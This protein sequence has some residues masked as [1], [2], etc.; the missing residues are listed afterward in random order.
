[1]PY[2]AGIDVSNHQGVIDWRR[3]AQSGIMFAIT[4]A[5]EG[6][7]FIDSTLQANWAGIKANGMYRGSYHFALPQINDPVDEAD[8]YL[9]TMHTVG[10]SVGDVLAVDV[11]EHYIHGPLPANTR[12]WLDQFVLSVHQELG[13]WP[14]IYTRLDLINRYGLAQSAVLG[15]CGLWLASWG[16]PT[17]PPAPR[18]WSVVA[19][20]QTGVGNAGT[21]PG[22]DGQIDLDAFNGEIVNFPKYG[23]PGTAPIPAPLPNHSVGP[24]I[25]Y[26]MSELLDGPATDEVYLTPQ[27]SEAVGQSGNIYRWVPSLGR[28]LVFFPE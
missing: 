17:P 9:R 11:E 23:I 15:Q 1:M 16:V 28:V 13:L 2:P 24:G 14:L 18:P 21:V 27:W 26:K 22:V 25:M 7:T 12:P 3:V 10:L 19:V 5:T 6:L 20:H 4:K 8:F